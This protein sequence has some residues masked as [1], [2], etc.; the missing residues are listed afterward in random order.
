MHANWTSVSAAADDGPPA[1]R[2]APVQGDVVAV[3][4]VGG[5]LG[6]LGRWA[7]SLG[8]DA[9]PGRFP[10]ATFVENVSGGFALGVLMVL[11]LDVW[12]ASRY[13]RPFFGVGILGGYTTFSTYMLDT[14]SLVVDDH[15]LLAAVYLLG[16]LV[17]GLA[18][19]WAGVVVARRIADDRPTSGTAS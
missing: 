15:L 8:L 16:T 17:A 2:F 13:V 3:V 18:S 12:P 1:P 7:L 14:R 11:V 4:A 5:A 6:S 9:S 19:V 10:W